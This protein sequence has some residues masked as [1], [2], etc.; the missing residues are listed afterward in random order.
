MNQTIVLTLLLACGTA[1]AAEWVSL[2][3]SADGTWNFIDAS[4]I[5]VMGAIRV[6]RF[7]R[8][9][10]PHTERGSGADAKRWLS[11][12]VG[13][14]AFNCAEGT[15]RHEG[16]TAYWDD[17]SHTP[18]AGHFPEPWTPI[19]LDTISN[20]QAQFICAWRPN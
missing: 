3:K 7:K 9:S 4:R 11:Y 2:G 14:K 5:R 19:L 15:S 16:W 12:G 10:A 1:Q 17:G 20:G 8:V 6:A 13:R 18:G